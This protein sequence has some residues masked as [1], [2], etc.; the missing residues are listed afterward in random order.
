MNVSINTASINPLRQR[1]QHDMMMRVFGTL[2]PAGPPDYDTTL[3]IAF[4]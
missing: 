4:R 1:M 2:A 3:A